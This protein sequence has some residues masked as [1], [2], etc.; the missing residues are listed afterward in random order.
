MHNNT[1]LAHF[2]TVN[3]VCVAKPSLHWRVSPTRAATAPLEEASPVE[4]PGLCQV[5]TVCR[6]LFFFKNQSY[7][8]TS[9]GSK[10]GFLLWQSAINQ[11][12]AV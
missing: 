10:I 5:R 11:Q 4:I 2:A 3:G 1:T 8:S 7:K 9:V 6:P 12:V